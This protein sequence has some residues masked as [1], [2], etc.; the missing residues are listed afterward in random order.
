M[1]STFLSKITINDAQDIYLVDPL[2]LSEQEIDQL[3]DG[4]VN[5][6]FWSK[7]SK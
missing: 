6:E 3:A 4:V 7:L 1:G 2:E 5:A